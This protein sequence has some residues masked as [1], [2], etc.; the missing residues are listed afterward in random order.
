MRRDPCY[1]TAGEKESYHMMNVEKL[2][3]ILLGMIAIFL[4]VLILHVWRNYTRGK[5]LEHLAFLDEVTGGINKAGF[6]MKYQKLCEKGCADQ[7]VMVLMD[8]V[9]FQRI[10]ANFGRRSGD[11]ALRYFYQSMSGS[12]RK[13]DLECVARTEMDHF[14]LCLKET[15]PE[16]IQ[17]RLDDIVGMVHRYTKIMGL[18]FKVQFRVG[19]SLITDNETDI[20]VL[21]D[22]ARAA[23]KIQGKTWRK[24]CAFYNAEVAHR[25]KKERDLDQLFDRSVRE[26][27][28][29]V[30]M[31]P[32]V[33][34]ETG[35]IKG[36]EAL[37]RWDCPGRGVL[38][39]DEFIPMLERNGKIRMLDRYVFENVCRWLCQRKEQGEPLFPVSVNLSRS[40]FLEDDFL[41]SF[42][43]IAETYAVETSLIEFEVT[44]T[45]FLN[46]NHLK[47]VG[48]HIGAMHRYGF[49]CAL[50]D[51][52]VGYSSLI[53]LKELQID[54]LKLDRSFVMDLENEKTQRVIACVVNLAQQ[55]NLDLVVE[56]IET[57]EQI[58][59][60]KILGCDIVQ[61]YYFSRPL[62]V[63]A[64]EHWIQEFQTS[65]NR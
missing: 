10:N 47:K 20:T 16:K 1:K 55:L 36:A 58:R 41:E 26:E 24:T 7:Y 6:R 49:K 39:P 54:V 17:K 23:L 15:D 9:D 57:S 59:Y 45:I 8:V 51:F 42:A 14:F 2:Q 4:F 35:C 34:V 60:M 31:Q 38:C 21:L 63:Y 13:S 32:K 52:G 19:A 30:Y 61:G 46:K 5:R 29:L 65:G 28:F 33:N 62:P 25:I 56:G 11:K 44:E 3:M 50:D 48:E 12:L 22:Q 64:F 18:T 27:R 40:H 37:V 43:E 53:S